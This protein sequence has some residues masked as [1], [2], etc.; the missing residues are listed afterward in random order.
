MNLFRMNPFYS[1]QPWYDEKGIY[2]LKKKN[3]D[4]SFQ[5]FGTDCEW[6]NIYTGEIIN[7]WDRNFLPLNK[8]QSRQV[9]INLIIK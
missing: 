7:N 1:S 8:E 3:I 6:E 5:I 9:L 4:R 2:V